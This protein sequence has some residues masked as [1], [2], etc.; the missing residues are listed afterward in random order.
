MNTL[1][2]EWNVPEDLR[3]KKTRQKSKWHLNIVKKIGQGGFGS[4][5]SGSLSRVILGRETVKL[6]VK[7]QDVADHNY[8]V[9]MLRKLSHPNIVPL[10]GDYIE[11]GKG[12]LAVPMYES[13]LREWSG[14]CHGILLDVLSGLEYLKTQD[15]VHC[16][17]KSENICVR[18]TSRGPEGVI[19]D[20]GLA[21]KNGEDDRGVTPEY[22]QKYIAWTANKLVVESLDHRYDLFCLG[23]VAG[24]VNSSDK[25]LCIELKELLENEIL[26]GVQKITE[27]VPSLRL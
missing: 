1:S 5:Y 7:E 26:E 27:K 16:D 10:L 17:I 2:R 23:V 15:I 22:L 12:F 9:A 13:N 14:E 20:F 8:E 18:L 24:N 6:A 11:N 21:K 4:V 19:I 25:E 3:E